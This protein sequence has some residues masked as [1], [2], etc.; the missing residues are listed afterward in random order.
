MQLPP[1]PPV[2][3]PSDPEPAPAVDNDVS[4]SDESAIL[5]AGDKALDEPE[6]AFVPVD[7]ELVR[8][9]DENA[10]LEAEKSNLET[11]LGEAVARATK[12]E[13]AEADLKKAANAGGWTGAMVFIAPESKN[14]HWCE[15]LR[16]M[17]AKNE[18]WTSGPS[19]K[20]HFWIRVAE[21]GPWPKIVYYDNGKARQDVVYGFDGTKESFNM[22]LYKSPHYKP[23]FRTAMTLEKGQSFAS[24]GDYFAPPPAPAS[25]TTESASEPPLPP[26]RSNDRRSA[27]CS[28]SYSSYDEGP[29]FM[30]NCSGG[31]T[32]TRSGYDS[33]GKYWTAGDNYYPSYGS[34]CSGGGYSSYA[35]APVVYSYPVYS[36]AYSANCSG[37]SFNGPVYS[38][39]GGYYG[40]PIYN[41]YGSSLQGGVSLGGFG[42]GFG[43]GY[44]PGGICP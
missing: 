28:G 1:A 38:S 33:D 23:K 44:C 22:I 29:K 24:V 26:L 43:G 8:L 3:S 41:S 42:F 6:T 17:L 21:K 40:G 2:P 27:S 37:N 19:E 5:D 11:D 32:V 20:Y 13:Q 9:Q 31:F 12:A 15:V 35:S 36:S 10:K 18:D 25:E 34:N 16:E 30:G 7:P 4:D 14:C 39:Y